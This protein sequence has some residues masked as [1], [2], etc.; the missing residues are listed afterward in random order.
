[1]AGWL[2]PGV[3]LYAHV[4]V[5]GPEGWRRAVCLEVEGSVVTFGV[6]CSVEEQQRLGERYA[7]IEVMDY[8]SLVEAR[9]PTRALR[10]EAPPGANNLALP[11]WKH[12]A[13]EYFSMETDGKEFATASE[14]EPPAEDR[15]ELLRRIAT[16][17]MELQHH[18][19]VART[20]D[21]PKTAPGWPQD[22]HVAPA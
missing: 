17:E 1:M 8:G 13:R 9:G 6:P 12:L 18:H 10:R 14:L 19:S 16:L 2:H 3:E 4:S 20:S 5:G 21:G 22:Q 7:V 15:E 11:R